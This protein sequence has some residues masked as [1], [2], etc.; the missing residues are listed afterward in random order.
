MQPISLQQTMH[1]IAERKEATVQRR[2]R[3]QGEEARYTLILHSARKA[4][5]ITINEYCLA[6]TVHKLS[7]NRST[8]PGWCYASK[9]H[10]GSVLG[11]SRR[12]IHNMINS[13]KGRG[14]LELQEDTGYLRTTEA[15]R[16]AVEVLRT[17]VFAD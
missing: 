1:R 17:K 15:W 7:G 11:V 3:L 8:V 10:L 13:L 6:D 14:I 16:E 2:K 12:S 5:D 4:L 9:E